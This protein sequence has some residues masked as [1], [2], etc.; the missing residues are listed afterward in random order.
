LRGLIRRCTTPGVSEYSPSDFPLAQLD[1]ARLSALQ[2]R[3]PD[4]E[5]IWPLAPMQQI[6][7][8]HARRSPDSVA[9]HEQ[10][11]L[12]LEGELDEAALETAWRELAVRHAAMRVAISNAAGGA[13]LQVVR[14]DARPPWQAAD[15]S[16]LD[17]EVT[18]RRLQDLLAEDRAQGFDLASG[19]LLRVCLLRHSPARHS[20]ILSFH[21][22]LLDGWSIPIML[23]ELLELYRAARQR[24]AAV[25]PPARHYRDHL[26]WLAA[27]DRTADEA[28]WCNRL[29][30][31][32][33]PRW[34][35]LPPGDPSVSPDAAGEHRMT[36]SE[37]LTGQLQ[38]L[39]QARRLTMNTL[40]Q[41]AWALALGR[42]TP[43]SDVVFG[44]TTA[45]RPGELP[46]V[47]QM[48]GLCINILPRRVRLDAMA[49]VTDWLGDLQLRQAEE[50]SHDRCSLADIQRWR[51][52][53]AGEALFDSVV[54]FENYPVGTTLAGDAAVSPAEISVSAVA[55]FEEGIDFPLCLVAGPGAR[56][57][58]RLI[59]SRRYFDAA[60]VS[61]LA[62]DLVNLL[63]TI[64][65]DPEKP[66][67]ALRGA[68]CADTPYAAPQ[69]DGIS[70]PN[71]E[72]LP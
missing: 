50:Q 43:D 55:S 31:L 49:R 24:R 7:L 67:A 11:C 9:Y 27:A 15:W 71:S 12:T 22:L 23:R 46:G 44:M 4:I 19:M 65:A 68:A 57:S 21:H 32:S 2:Q 28:F 8:S 36:L 25:L 30:G 54:V 59:F 3:Y 33:G 26:T 18:E 41:G 45:G 14:R 13:S 72:S 51:S 39:A 1:E 66:L 58:F 20:M 37:R 16:G 35:D 6:M 34:L 42:H 62:D 64:A 70:L 40:V 69:S 10:L 47:E 5:D 48:V 53:P 17:A 56:M 38:A 29:A 61:E 52:A 60:A 63:T